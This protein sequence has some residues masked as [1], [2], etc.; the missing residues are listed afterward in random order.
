M[1]MNTYALTQKC[2]LVVTPEAACAIL[3]K[4]AF[5]GADGAAHIPK[6]ALAAL[7]SGRA[8][9]DVA[10]DPAFR[11]ELEDDGWFNVSDAHDVLQA[12]DLDGV[13]YCSEFD[14]TAAP[15]SSDGFGDEKSKEIG[16]DDDYLA[17]LAPNK[18][19]S[20]F[21]AA[22]RSKDDLLQEYEE[23]LSG[24]VGPGFPYGR[25]VMDVD[26]TYFC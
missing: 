21:V 2:A 20:L 3:L 16:F 26:G 10:D 12:A 9:W 4:E 11:R 6:N 13:V 24:F 1:S 18:E 14:G 17:F 5:G 23:R 15:A 22:Y 19:P 8:P 7:E 25:F